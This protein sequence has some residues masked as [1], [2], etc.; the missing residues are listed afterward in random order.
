MLNK[1]VQLECENLVKHHV[2][3]KLMALNPLSHTETEASVT[4]KYSFC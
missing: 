4:E 3:V 2:G 1:H